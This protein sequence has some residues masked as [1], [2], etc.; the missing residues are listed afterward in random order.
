MGFRFRKSFKIAPGV[1][2]NVGK[3]SVGVSIGGKRAGVSFNS[4]TGARARVSAPGTGLSY[5]TKLGKKGRQSQ[6]AKSPVYSENLNFGNSG[7]GQPPVSPPNPP[8]QSPG[9]I[10]PQKPR[11]K[12]DIPLILLSIFLPFVAIVFLWLYS[13][14]KDRYSL[15]FRKILTAVLGVYTVIMIIATA[16]SP[17]S[18]SSS[19]IDGGPSYSM[20]SPT[21]APSEDP[22]PT[23]S[24]TP[25]STP[26]P[27][28]TPTPKT[29]EKPPVATVNPTPKPTPEPTPEATP[30][31]TAKPTKNP[32]PKPTEKPPVS[33][34]GRYVGSIDSDKYHYPSC[35]FAE[36]ILPENE[37]WFNSEEDAK[38]Q[39]YVPCGVCKP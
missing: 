1:K 31:P 14:W 3:K 26:E 12:R 15:K 24:P 37:I 35:R 19:K 27:T 22:K 34:Q 7:G 33:S 32:T 6:G 38:A 5:S 28:A 10:P 4:R 29:T 17:S 8:S 20:S 18:S 21:P 25:E 16:T 39:G 11:K 2:F 23:A 9:G 36:E 13:D 30:K